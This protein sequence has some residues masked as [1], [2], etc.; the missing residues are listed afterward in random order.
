MKSSAQYN[1]NGYTIL[2]G[3][4][5][6]TEIATIENHVERIYKKWVKENESEIFNQKLVNMHSLTH[7]E[8]FNGLQ[9]ERIKFFEAIASIKL[10]DA[11]DDLFGSGIH[12]HNTQLFFNPSNQARLP[13]WHR[14]TQYSPIDD[15]IQKAEQHNILSLHIRI[16]LIQEKGVEVVNGTHKRWDTE[17]EHNVRLELNGHKNSEPL[18]NTTLIDLSPG[19]VLIF[20][21]QMIHRGNYA[22]NPTR[23]ALDLC[24]GKYHSLTSDFLDEQVLPQEEEMESIANNKWYKLAREIAANKLSNN[25]LRR[26]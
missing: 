8:Y 3:F 1:D 22:L 15:V 9:K 10:T 18:P 14:D 4:F 2:R 21:A 13:Y 11:L 20:N 6:N 16:P 26:R 25:S 12:F 19:D 7:S 17:L 24:V 23:K 5:S